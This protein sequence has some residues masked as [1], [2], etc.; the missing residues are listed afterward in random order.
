[1]FYKDGKGHP[2]WSG[3]N[4]FYFDKRKTSW[5][6]IFES[7]KALPA[8]SAYLPCSKPA[9]GRQQHKNR[10]EPHYDT[11]VTKDQS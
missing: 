2:T 4:P 1:M 5:P 9:E 11:T 6:C 10:L 3:T 7:G 8:P